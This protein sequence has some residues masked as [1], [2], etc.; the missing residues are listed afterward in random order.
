MLH[1]SIFVYVPSTHPYSVF[2]WYAPKLKYLQGIMYHVEL[3]KLLFHA[4]TLKWDCG[5]RRRKRKSFCIVCDRP[6]C[7]LIEE[8]IQWRLLSGGHSHSWGSYCAVKW[9]WN[10]LSEIR[11]HDL[12]IERGFA[13]IFNIF[14]T[15]SRCKY[16][17]SL[18]V[19]LFDIF[20]SEL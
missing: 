3:K 7:L 9:Q 13:L 18:F 12:E 8:K 11:R 19:L 20:L 4:I 1:L 10:G 2:S 17:V 5:S 15:L 6:K 16:F 14:W